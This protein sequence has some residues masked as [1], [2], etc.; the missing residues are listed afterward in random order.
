VYAAFKIFLGRNPEPSA[1]AH[2]TKIL[3]KKPARTVLLDIAMSEE[4]V[5][6]RRIGIDERDRLKTERDALLA[7]RDALRNVRNNLRNETYG[8]RSERDALR[9][10]RNNLRNE[11][12]GLRSEGDAV[13]GES[14]VIR[15]DSE[16]MRSDWKVIRKEKIPLSSERDRRAVVQPENP[17]GRK[18]VQK[19]LIK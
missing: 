1:I 10:V 2:Y 8:L 14:S 17:H 11:T 7:D 19:P 15:T 6:F 13:L 5:A 16:T 3:K 12:Y 9:N 18:D 4:A